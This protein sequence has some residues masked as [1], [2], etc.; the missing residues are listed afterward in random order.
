MNFTAQLGVVTSAVFDEF[1]PVNLT[2]LKGVAEHFKPSG[3]PCDP[4]PPQFSKEA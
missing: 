1:E 2:F 3:S 4:A